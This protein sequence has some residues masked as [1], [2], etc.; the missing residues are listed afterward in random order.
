M[1]I[2]VD[3]LPKVKA[4]CP[5]YISDTDICNVCD[6]LCHLENCTCLVPFEISIEEGDDFDE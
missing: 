2:Y 6:K 4:E 1:R 3:E 5:F